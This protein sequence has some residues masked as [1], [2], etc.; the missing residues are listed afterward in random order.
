[1]WSFGFAGGLSSKAAANAFQSLSPSTNKERFNKTSVALSLALASMNS[2]R[3]WPSADAAR[4]MS[5]LVS[6][7]ILMLRGSALVT[8]LGDVA[9]RVAALRE[10]VASGVADIFV[11]FLLHRNV[12]HCIDNVNT[13]LTSLIERRIKSH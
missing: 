8:V 11:A 4:S 3:V 7:S 2:V 12:L 5:V 6:L 10:A 13:D 1:V 9:R